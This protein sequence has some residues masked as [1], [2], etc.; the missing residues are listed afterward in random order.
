MPGFSKM[1]FGWAMVHSFL[2]GGSAIGLSATDAW[3]SAVAGDDKNMNLGPPNSQP[4]TKIKK[5]SN[6]DILSY[7]LYCL[8]CLYY[9]SP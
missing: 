4:E 8:Y 6:Q 9:L 5:V 7:C 1:G 3:H 2:T